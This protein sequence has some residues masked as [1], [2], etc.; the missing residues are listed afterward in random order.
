MIYDDDLVVNPGFYLS[1]VTTGPPPSA[2]CSSSATLT[3]SKTVESGEHCWGQLGL[4]KIPTSRGGLLPMEVECEE[5]ET[6]NIWSRT[7]SITWRKL[8]NL[9]N[10]PRD[11]KHFL[12]GCKNYV[13]LEKYWKELGIVVNVFTHYVRIDGN[14]QLLLRLDWRDKWTHSDIDYG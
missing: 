14:K 4:R 5:E 10:E 13:W 8:F 6:L 9:L 7:L 2:W 12:G 3:R 1:T 11:L